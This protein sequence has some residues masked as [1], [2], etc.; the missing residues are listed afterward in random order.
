MCCGVLQCVAVCCSV[1]QC[2][3]V[4]NWVAMCCS[5]LQ[6]VEV[7]CSVLRCV[8]VCCSVLQW[9]AVSCSVLQCVAVCCLRVAIRTWT[10]KTMIGSTSW[11]TVLSLF[12]LHLSLFVSLKVSFLCLKSL[13]YA[14]RTHSHVCHYSLAHVSWLMPMCD[15]THACVWHDSLP[16]T[17][18][19]DIFTCEIWLIHMW[20]MTH[21]Y[22]WH[23]SFIYV[24]WLIHMRDMTHSYV[25]QASFIFVTCLIHICDMTHS[26]VWL[27]SLV[28]VTW[29]IHMCDMT[30]SYVW[31]DSFICVTCLIH[32]CD[33]THSYVWRTHSYVWHDSITSVTWLMHM[34]DMTHSYVWHDSCICVT[35]L[36]HSIHS[37]K[38]PSVWHGLFTQ[39]TQYTA[40]SCPHQIGERR[41][42]RWNARKRVGRERV[43]REIQRFWWVWRWWWGVVCCSVLQCVALWCSVVQC[44]AVWCSVVQCDAVWGALCCNMV[45]HAVAVKN[46]TLRM[47]RMTRMRFRVF[48]SV[49]QY[50]VAVSCCSEEYNASDESDDEDEVSVFCSVLQCVAACCSELLQWVIAVQIATLQMSLLTIMSQNV[51]QCVAVCCSVL[52]C[53]AFIKRCCA[54]MKADVV[55]EYEGRR[56]QGIQCYMYVWV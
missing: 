11:R 30:H 26:Y 42:H 45:K 37:T 4:L 18:P 3:S 17:H 29:L 36:I 34:C 9:V 25:W 31:L 15:M 24:T 50:V 7:C 54:N 28:C 27:D 35:W 47:S 32:M 56:Q 49:L 10:S 43:G 14:Y 2:C 52:Q 44:G 6:C 20:D 51:F 53:V 8:A 38:L 46:T 12:C 55:C 13:L 41:R 19:P 22:V 16:H 23:D 1:L 21:S 33:M 39:H 48:C 40:Q 5:V